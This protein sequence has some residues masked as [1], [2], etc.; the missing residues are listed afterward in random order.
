MWRAKS[1]S[2]RKSDAITD[3]TGCPR[4]SRRCYAPTPPPDPEI[5]RDRLVRRV[6]LAGR[7]LGGPDLHVYRRGDGRALRRSG[8]IVPIGNPL[9]AQFSVLRPSLL[10][11]RAGGRRAQQQSRSGPTCCLFEIGAAVTR[12]GEARRVAIVWTGDASGA[13]W[14]GEAPS[15]DFFDVK[16]LVERS[17]ARCRSS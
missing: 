15:V 1:I 7:L 10:A 13:H 14:S 17:P 9:S 5:E 16:G 8:A 4:R 2:S 12:A 11:G 6:L 3:T